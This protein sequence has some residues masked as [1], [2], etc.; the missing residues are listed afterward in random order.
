MLGILFD[1]IALLVITF[2]VARE[3]SS[4]ILKI[5]L[6]S[7]GVSVGN[8]F[9]VMALGESLGILVLI[10]IIAVYWFAIMYFITHTIGRTAV[11]V[12]L[13]IICKVLFFLLL[14]DL[15]G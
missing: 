14:T 2:L 3:E 13:L 6:V 5:F 8:F 11:A 1:F 12:T 7:V 4:E 15:A 9:L 10:P